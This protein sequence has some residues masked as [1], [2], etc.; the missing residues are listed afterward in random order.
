MAHHEL[1]DASKLSP[2]EKREEFK[3]DL[4][5]RPWRDPIGPGIPLS[6]RG[7]AAP[8]T[9]HQMATAEASE[10]GGRFAKDRKY[11][12]TSGGSHYPPASGPWCDP[13]NQALNASKDELG[14]PIDEMPITAGHEFEV[15]RAAAI[16][17]AQHAALEI[18][19]SLAALSDEGLDL[20]HRDWH[21]RIFGAGAGAAME[22]VKAI[23]AEQAKRALAS[24]GEIAAT[25][26]APDDVA[27]LSEAPGASWGDPFHRPK[28]GI[29]RASA[30][31]VEVIAAMDDE[32]LALELARTKRRQMVEVEYNATLEARELAL[33]AEIA[34][35]RQSK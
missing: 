4:A 6:P 18:D 2:N 17:E 19:P 25:H 16:L 11:D 28:S 12:V 1:G 23:E 27:P 20:A 9:F 3:A 21:G 13:L 32:T 26:V 33:E 5:R 22:R 15:D 31:D 24:R 34:R 29:L 7:P 8:T 30:T 14:Y 35:R 10:E